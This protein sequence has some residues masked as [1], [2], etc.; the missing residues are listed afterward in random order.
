VEA[1]PGQAA[2]VQ[3]RFETGE[4]LVEVVRAGRRS[5]G[6]VIL[7][8]AD[9]E[10][11][12][13]SAGV[14]SRVATGTYTVVVESRGERRRQEGLAITRGEQRVLRFEFGAGGSPK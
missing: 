1:A 2:R 5:V 3:A 9:A 12:R 4:L 7:Q 8:R 13:G 14:A 6:L 10:I 11:G